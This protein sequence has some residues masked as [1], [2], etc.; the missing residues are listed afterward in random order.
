MVPCTLSASLYIAARH[1]THALAQTCRLTPLFP[2]FTRAPYPLYLINWLQCIVYMTIITRPVPTTSLTPSQTPSPTPSSTSLTP[3]PTP[4]P[5]SLCVCGY[6]IK[7]KLEKSKLLAALSRPRRV[8][9]KS[10]EERFEEAGGRAVMDYVIEGKYKG[11]SPRLIS[12]HYRDPNP[13]LGGSSRVKNIFQGMRGET[14]K[15]L[16]M[17]FMNAHGF[18]L[19][20]HYDKPITFF[21]GNHIPDGWEDAEKMAP[22]PIIMR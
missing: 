9:G 17:R 6:H 21:V 20:Q 3:S 12:L 18:R 11:Y 14:A 1:A 8:G 19:C 10:D 15:E 7:P 4:S 2:R 5:S 22:P 13:L 16:A